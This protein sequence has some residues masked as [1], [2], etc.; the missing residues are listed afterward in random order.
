MDFSIL[1]GGRTN[2]FQLDLWSRGRRLKEGG[3]KWT[4]KDWEIINPKEVVTKAF[5]GESKHNTDPSLA[6]DVAPYPIDFASRT[7]VLAR[8]YY[9]AGLIISCAAS[10]GIKLRWGGD[11]DGDLDFEDQTFD[12][13]GH[14]EKVV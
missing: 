8:F 9:L 5:P 3:D 12:D 4:K 7:K 11:W 14:F 2:E 1:Y 10:L 13:L 6:F